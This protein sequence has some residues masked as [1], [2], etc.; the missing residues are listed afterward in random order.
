MKSFIL[1]FLTFVAFLSYILSL[2]IR[3]PSPPRANDLTDH[4]GTN[5]SANKY[6]PRAP[7]VPSGQLMRQGI[8]SGIPITPITNFEQQ[9]NP[10]QVVAG[11]LLNTAPDAKKIEKPD[12]AGKLIQAKSLYFLIY[13]AKG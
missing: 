13:S 3:L 11:N 2:N 5:P 6:G 10:K 9:I 8:H 12:M 4:F 7:I 1:K